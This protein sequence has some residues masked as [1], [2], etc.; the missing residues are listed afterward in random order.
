[1]PTTIVII[2]GLALL[3]L[4][5][6]VAHTLGGAAGAARGALDFCLFGW[7]AQESTCTSASEE[8]GRQPKR[9]PFSSSCLPFRQ[10]PRVWSGEKWHTDSE[11]DVLYFGGQRGHSD[12]PPEP[13]AYLIGIA[14]PVRPSA[15]RAESL[16]VRSQWAHADDRAEAL[17]ELPS[18][19]A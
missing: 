14:R 15:M 5:L 13:Q 12:T 9:P 6:R 4:C 2:G 19:L 10:A 7:S 17:R 18:F 8:A 16:R 1:M 3:G 11:R